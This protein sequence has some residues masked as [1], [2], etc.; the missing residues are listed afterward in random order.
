MNLAVATAWT[1]ARTWGL[2][3]ALAEAVC[4]REGVCVGLYVW[5]GGLPVAVALAVALASAAAGGRVVTVLLLQLVLLRRAVPR[6]RHDFRVTS[7]LLLLLLLQ[8]LLQ[9]LQLLE[10][11]HLL[12]QLLLLQLLLLQL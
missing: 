3:L 6:H 5:L 12:L 11:V 8:M 10:L 1:A 4:M 9:L 7:S 2:M